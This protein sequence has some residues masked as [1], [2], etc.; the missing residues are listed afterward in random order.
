MIPGP[1]QKPQFWGKPASKLMMT[2][3]KMQSFLF[4]V[5]E[6]GYLGCWEKMLTEVKNTD[7]GMMWPNV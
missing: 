3:V 5:E 4:V 6:V 2:L 1:L 7:L